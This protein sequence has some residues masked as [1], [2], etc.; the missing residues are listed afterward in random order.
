M[1]SQTEL[2]LAPPPFTPKALV[3]FVALS[4]CVCCCHYRL[5]SYMI[6]SLFWPVELVIERAKKATIH[7]W[8]HK[9]AFRNSCCRRRRRRRWVLSCLFPY[10]SLDVHLPLLFVWLVGW[11]AQW[12]QEAPAETSTHLGI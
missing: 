5:L 1:D 8:T 4:V 11:F 3:G 10:G 6:T 12:N 7:T 9:Y 2:C